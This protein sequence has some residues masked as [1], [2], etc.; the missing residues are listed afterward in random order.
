MS[1]KILALKNPDKTCCHCLKETDGLHEIDIGDMGYGSG[2]DSWSTK[3][4][5]CE[6]CYKQ[7]EEWWKLKEIEVDVGC[8][9]SKFYQYK[10]E[11][12]IF[13][14]IQ[15]LPL[16][17]RELVLNTYKEDSMNP[18]DAQD[19]ID[20]E[21]GIIS[22][23]KCKEYGMYSPQERKAYEQRFPTCDHIYKKVYKD[24]SAGCYCPYGASGNSDGTCNSNI[25]MECYMCQHYTTKTNSIFVI[26]EFEEFVKDET[27]R[28][29]DMLKYST[30]RLKLI[31]ENPEQYFNK[32]ND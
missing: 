1:D 31:K 24:G 11:D 9:S 10:F 21:L 25:S 4:N 20:Y 23:D 19:W 2:F 16:Q 6:D 5:L 12:D 29:E 26:N 28:L 3:I 18:M 30:E 15:D 7:H 14:W 13:N 17:G 32:Y 27:E 8:P 22:H